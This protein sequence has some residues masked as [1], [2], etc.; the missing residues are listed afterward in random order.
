ATRLPYVGSCGALDMVNFGAM[1]T[2]PEQFRKRK[3]HVHNPQVTL[4]RTTP[5]ENRKFGAWLARKLNACEGDVRF[6]IPDGGVSLTDIPGQPLHDP[7][8]DAALLDAFE[9]DCVVTVRRRLPRLPFALS[10][11]QF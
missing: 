11:P 10:D 5:E 4:M 8:A 6:L 3:L 2:V 1:E 7:E 9:R